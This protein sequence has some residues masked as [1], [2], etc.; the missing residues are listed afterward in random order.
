MQH[1]PEVYL[2]ESR[3]LRFFLAVIQAQRDLV[4][5]RLRDGR[6]VGSSREVLAQQQICIFVCATLPGTLRIAK[7]D[8]H[9][10][11]YRKILVLRHLQSAV[12]RQRAFQPSR[13]LTNM[14]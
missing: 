11:S 14:L 12:P 1:W 9:I 3:S 7:V 4:E 6:Q 2:Q 5:L 10:R 8:L 13:E